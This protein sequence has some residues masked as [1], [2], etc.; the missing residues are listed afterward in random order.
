MRRRRPTP[1][2]RGDRGGNERG[3]GEWGQ[4]DEDHAIGEGDSDIIGNGEGEAGLTDAA[5]TGQRQERNGL[6]EEVLPGRARSL[7]ADEPGAGDGEGA[8]LER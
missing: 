7:P 2:A 3:I 5:G 1:S 8:E 4:V 6:P